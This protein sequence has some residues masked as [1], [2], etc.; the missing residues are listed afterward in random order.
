MSAMKKR[1]TSVVKQCTLA[2]AT[3]LLVGASYAN[4]EDLLGFK[5]DSH[6]RC[7][8]YFSEPLAVAQVP[9]PGPLDQQKT[10]ISARGLTT[11]R[12]DG[13]SVLQDHVVAV[14]PGRIAFADRALI[15]RNSKQAKIT[16]VRLIGHVKMVEHGHL[17]LADRA[18]IYLNSDHF[19]ADHVIY[20][21]AEQHSSLF[22]G[23]SVSANG[24][25]PKIVNFQH[26]TLSTCR[27]AHP[28]WLMH[29]K[30]VHVDKVAQRVKAYHVW[31]QLFHVPIFYA[32]FLSF[33]LNRDRK[34]GFLAP[35]WLSS[36]QS[37]KGVSVP[38]YW[39]IAPN[40]D[41]TLTSS[42]QTKRHFSER[43]LYRHLNRH[44]VGS[45]L[46]HFLPNDPVFGQFVRHSLDAIG[47]NSST[48]PYI[49]RLR[50]AKTF[51]WGLH[52]QEYW[53][54][55]D[56]KAGLLVNRVSDD[57][58]LQDFALSAVG[59]E[60]NLL[61]NRAYLSYTHDHWRSSFLAQGFQ[62]LHPIN[63]SGQ[64]DEY[65][66][67]PEW[68][69]NY[70]NPIGNHL[71][72]GLDA[73]WVRFAISPFYENSTLPEGMRYHWRPSVSWE[74]R[75]ASGYLKP[76]LSWD[77]LVYDTHPHT[78]T[79]AHNREQ[80][81]DVP[82]LSIDQSWYFRQLFHFSGHSYLHAIKPRLFYLYVPYR[83]Q[84]SLP[85]FSTQVANF[86]FEELYRD[87]RFTDIDRIANANQ[88]SIG[89]RDD[90]YNEN[91]QRKWSLGSGIIDY[92]V[93]QRVFLNQASAM[94]FSH[95]SPWVN[96]ITFYPGHHLQITANDAWDL[97][98]HTTVNAGM[99]LRYLYR[100]QN[101]IEW[102]YDFVREANTMNYER[103]HLG[104]GWSITSKWS[105]VAYWYYDMSR[106]QTNHYFAG[107]TYNSCCY[108]L[109][110]LVDRTYLGDTGVL[111][112]RQFDQRYWFQVVFK[113]L[114]GV[115]SAMIQPLLKANLPTYKDPL[116]GY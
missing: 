20:H 28:S 69:F 32:P 109:R 80:S 44:G 70:Y 113:G 61:F 38:F 41:M 4:I 5:A 36:S 92:F 43:I 48:K 83:D 2:T 71:N 40:Q 66:R 102:G 8:G 114:G 77:F 88:L 57:Y 30:K 87:N 72:L 50:A 21:I 10:H 13:T 103:F 100:P 39:N 106:R 64:A 42:Y 104:Y 76:K 18:T 31:L 17:I 12:P 24:H 33:S 25:Q 65:Q 53:H 23:K 19:T 94:D 82:M 1:L 52:G 27:P 84:D 68:D 11:I 45:F 86:N 107:L 99:L 96:E 16:R 89:L 26:G 73:Q 56:W 62:V 85:E 60:A 91:M 116:G 115:G 98:Q 78:P 111:G 90:I 63:Q 74:E 95:F 55:A 67:L 14:Q 34:T 108:A 75:W 7:G 46:F 93:P 6:L 59:A 35:T 47:Y 37:G 22:W 29:A 15:D 3:C 49:D 97:K 54:F 110:F 9:N 79:I 58:Y 101:M 81:R 51:R 105:S 112:R